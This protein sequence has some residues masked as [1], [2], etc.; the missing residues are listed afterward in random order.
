MTQSRTLE[1]AKS[2]LP[3]Q[4][5]EERIFIPLSG[6]MPNAFDK[7]ED[8]THPKGLRPRHVKNRPESYLTLEEVC[9]YL[10]DHDVVDGGIGLIPTKLS[11]GTHVV[12]KDEDNA[13]NS[14]GTL[15]DSAAEHCEIGDGFAKYKSCSGFGVHCIGI[16]SSENVALSGA[17][18]DLVDQGGHPEG[19]DAQIELL[20]SS[21]S[22]DGTRAISADHVRLSLEP[23]EIDGETDL[24]IDAEE[25]TRSWD[26]IVEDHDLA[27]SKVKA[28]KSSDGSYNY[29]DDV[30]ESSREI[31]IRVQDKVIR[32]NE[33]IDPKDKALVDLKDQI[34]SEPMPATGN[35]NSG[36][37]V[38]I[39]KT[40][41]MFR[42]HVGSA[43]LA[44]ELGEWGK[45]LVDDGFPQSELDGII[46]DA[47][48]DLDRGTVI[49]KA[50]E[51][52][53]WGWRELHE[54]TFKIDSPINGGLV[55]PVVGST[56]QEAAELAYEEW[57]I[58]EEE[59][60]Y[61]S[62]GNYTIDR[63]VE[64]SLHDGFEKDFYHRNAGSDVS[65]FSSFMQNVK[66]I[67]PIINGVLYKGQPVAA[68]GGSKSG[69]TTLITCDLALSCATHT[70]WLGQERFTPARAYKTLSLSGESA[71]SV[72]AATLKAQLAYR[73]LS[74]DDPLVN[75]NFNI[76][77]NVG[78]GTSKDYIDDLLDRIWRK[79]IEILF[80]DP[81]YFFLSS[82]KDNLNSS[83][84][85]ASV[86][87]PLRQGLDDLG[88]TLV[89]VDHTNKSASNLADKR[90]YHNVSM[91]DFQDNSKER[92]FRNFIMIKSRAVGMNDHTD[93][94]IKIELS[95]EGQGV[96]KHGGRFAVDVQT[97]DPFSEGSYE[98]ATQHDVTMFKSWN[99]YR[100]DYKKEQE[101]LAAVLEESKKD[102]LNKEVRDAIVTMT[103][104]KILR[105]HLDGELKDGPLKITPNA[106]QE[107]G[108]MP[109]GARTKSKTKGFMQD[110]LNLNDKEYGDTGLET[111]FWSDEALLATEA[112]VKAM[113]EKMA[114][115]LFND[116]L[117]TSDRNSGSKLSVE[118][119]C[120]DYSGATP[121]GVR[122]WLEKFENHNQT[123]GV[124]N[125]MRGQIPTPD[126]IGAIKLWRPIEGRISP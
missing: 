14:D 118:S 107:S 32:V 105:K 51:H 65:S 84:A 31:E 33:A 73:G 17:K 26:M 11:D 22:E 18:V 77:T 111:F 28:V 39:R 113:L 90:E 100:E 7:V 91:H 99:K 125:E 76:W 56:P 59:E 86:I 30:R 67:E 75:E 35:R 93:G 115:R 85:F 98:D 44:K 66:P 21:I 97:F 117:D 121:E 10:D 104:N 62:T 15:T 2:I 9:Q 69:K 27:S 46:A 45:P 109:D 64:R 94:K 12:V 36:A 79:Q 82:E 54:E 23:L 71:P 74:V 49:Y 92:Y 53:A 122:E 103:E 58:E 41:R 61:E 34:A 102:A 89:C 40:F 87:K 19:K 42:D 4:L 29:T 108:C 24:V 95:L 112:V 60:T 63:L 48:G 116:S 1:K 119:I 13:L 25:A 50:S 43:V 88:V 52:R 80:L 106:V 123:A 78:E 47:V 124:R 20:T 55:S 38:F 114:C 110:I 5:H 8:P 72:I 6:K 57:F 81:L 126:Q 16:V 83:N 37:M 68:G 120:Q 96:Q 3:N 101:A 70:P